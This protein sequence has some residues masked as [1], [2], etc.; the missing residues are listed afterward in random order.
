M[1]RP[2]PSLRQR[3]GV[4]GWMGIPRP[5]RLGRILQLPTSAAAV[6]SRN[7]PCFS[8]VDKSGSGSGRVGQGDGAHWLYKARR[9]GGRLIGRRFCLVL[10]RS[11]SA[12][13]SGAAARWSWAGR[14]EHLGEGEED[15]RELLGSPLSSRG[16]S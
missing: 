9:E 6:T 7:R 10:I 16:L 2:H 3:G 4:L 13:S 1:L 12:A 11:K 14:C 5:E 8:E 15:Q